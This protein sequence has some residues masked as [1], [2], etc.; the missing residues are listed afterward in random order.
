MFMGLNK[1]QHSQHNGPYS[2]S[3]PSSTGLGSPVFAIKGQQTWGQL[4]MKISKFLLRR[5]KSNIFKLPVSTLHNFGEMGVIPKRA[6]H[7]G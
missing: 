4:P 5:G 1:N 3:L 2:G 7:A 6:S